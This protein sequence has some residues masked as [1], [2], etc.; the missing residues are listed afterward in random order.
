MRTHPPT[1]VSAAA[2]AAAWV[3]VAALAGAVAAASADQ[4]SV[5]PTATPDPA[6][7]YC[8]VTGRQSARPATIRRNEWVELEVALSAH[9]P[10]EARGRS[11]ILL[12]VDHSSSMT[13]DGKYEGS[14]AAVRQFVSEVDFQRHRVGLLMFNERPWVAQ[15][16]TDRAD[17]VLSA[18]LGVGVPR[19]GTDIALAL[20][21]AEEELRQRGRREAVPIVVL[22]TDGLSSVEAMIAA[23]DRSRERGTVLFVIGLGADAD[24][25]VLREVASTRDHFYYAPGPELLGE[26]YQR[27]AAMI[28]EFSVTNVTLYDRPASGITYV[29]GSGR[30]SEPRMGS[31]LTWRR[32]F[33]LSSNTVIA[34]RLRVPHIGRLT[35]S[36]ALWV[37]FTDGDGVLRRV[38]IP[39]AALDV[40]EAEVH[41]AFLPLAWRNTCRPIK[42]WVD[43]ALVLDASSSMAGEKLAQALAAAR[44]FVRLIDLTDNRAAIVR[45]DENAALV[46]PLTS[47]RAALLA[48]LDGLNTGRGTRHDRGIEVAL[49]ELTGPRGRPENRQAIILLSDGR[50]VDQPERARAW[51]EYAWARGVLVYTIALGEDADRDMLRDL[52]DHPAHAYYAPSADQLQQ[53][54]ERL[55]GAVRCR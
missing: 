28:R 55:A 32:A 36:A 23:G 29:P 44:T 2:L 14:A 50:Q 26:I 19:G 12:V 24:Q 8:T 4:S 31:Q 43:V 25:R 52:A 22:M 17:R 45:Y 54:Y 11:D 3:T 42:Q 51:A 40:L 9:C 38:D 21:A 49:A 39:P 48:A 37:E 7:G 15:P 13:D 10:D 6:P 41:A 35:P 16:L 20:S 33:L 34:Y 46:L 1:R 47:D 18:F 5:P 30:P 27:I 53:I